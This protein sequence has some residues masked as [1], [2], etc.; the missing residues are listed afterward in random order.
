M[1]PACICSS[2]LGCGTRTYP[3]VECHF[4]ETSVLTHSALVPASFLIFRLRLYP[5]SSAGTRAFYSPAPTPNA[6]SIGLAYA[7][8]VTPVPPTGLRWRENCATE[9]TAR[10]FLAGRLPACAFS[11]FF[12]LC[13]VGSRGLACLPGLAIARSVVVSS[14]SGQ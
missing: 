11:V 5:P 6:L 8:A 13:T 10:R 4:Q 3:V 12:F 2:V 7:P 1:G 9:Q 14:S